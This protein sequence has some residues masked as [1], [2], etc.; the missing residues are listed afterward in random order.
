MAISPNLTFDYRFLVHKNE[1]ARSV[2]LAW[3]R[4]VPLDPSLE[5]S[6]WAG[7]GSGHASFGRGDGLAG[8][9]PRF[10]L[11]AGWLTLIPTAGWTQLLPSRWFSDAVPCGPATAAEWNADSEEAMELVKQSGPVTLERLNQAEQMIRHRKG[12]IRQITSYSL[13]VGKA[14]ERLLQL[15]DELR[16]IRDGNADFYYAVRRNSEIIFSAGAVAGRDDG[17]TVAVWQQHDKYPNPCAEAAKEQLKDH[18]KSIPVAETL[19]LARPYIT[20]R[21]QDQFSLLLDGDEVVSYPYYVYLARSNQ[22]VPFFSFEFTPRAVH[23]RGCLDSLE[24]ASI[25]DAALQLTAPKTRLL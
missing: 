17:G 9:A 12:R 10:E 14:M 19:S 24:K 4:S 22:D 8:P 16:F 21:V 3:A 18:A 25:I 6:Y 11:F 1:E 5:N 15:G 2:N 20:V 7:S 23:A 13:F